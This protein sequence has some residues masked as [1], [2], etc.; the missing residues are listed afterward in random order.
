MELFNPVR[1]N[2]YKPI[3]GAGVKHF[4]RGALDGSVAIIQAHKWV[5]TQNGIS[6]RCLC[7]TVPADSLGFSRV[8]LQTEQHT[9][10]RSTVSKVIYSQNSELFFFLSCGSS[11]HR[12]VYRFSVSAT[13]HSQTQLR[14]KSAFSLMWNIYGYKL[15]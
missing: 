8:L 6:Q 14:F 10:L 15:N 2:P 13:K 3:L 12:S 9:S 5:K 1:N 4:H 7:A 11:S